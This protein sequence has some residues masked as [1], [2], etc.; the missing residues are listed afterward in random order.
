MDT[1]SLSVVIPALDEETSIEA[2]V[3]AASDAQEVIVVDGGSRDETVVRAGE[4]GAR[5]VIGPRGRGRQMNLGASMCRGDVLVFLHADTLLPR[6][7]DAQIRESL[8]AGPCRW[9][10]FDVRFDRSTPI[11]DLI[12]WLISTRSRLT[13]GATGDQAI[14]VERAL[15][16]EIGGY[17]DEPLFEDVDLCRR[18]K[19]RAAMA[20]PRSPVTTSSRRWRTDGVI[21][22][23]LLMWVL[24]GLY[25]IGVP[26]GRLAALYRNRR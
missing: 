15:F 23:S 16:E 24:K 2:T 18:L 26:A 13:R 19:R 12:A 14:F 21:R 7:Y 6:D 11:L 1:V 10:R 17:I 20:V 22:T 25:L 9:G 8:A 3:A 4:A 5:V